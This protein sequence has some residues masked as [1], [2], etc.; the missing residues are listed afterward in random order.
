MTPGIARRRAHGVVGEGQVPELGHGG[1]A[2]DDGAGS[3]EPLNGRGVAFPHIVRKQPR[4]S[5]ERHALHLH[6]HLHGHR[7]AVERSQRIAAA[8]GGVGRVGRGQRS[9]G[10]KV[11]EGVQARFRGLDPVEAR[12]H[13]FARSQLTA[14]DPAGNVN[15]PRVGQIVG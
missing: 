15:R 2:D 10:R 9:L 4:A 6:L 1:H 7:H 8:H 13:R 3:L 12:R 14:A 5:V 11:H